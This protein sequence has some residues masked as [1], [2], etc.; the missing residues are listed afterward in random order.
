MHS[1][2][3]DSAFP[4]ATE[5]DTRRRLIEAAGEV[6]AEL[7]FRAATVR[8]ITERAGV[9]VAAINYH[10]RDKTE[11][12]AACLYHAKCTAIEAAGEWGCESDEPEE[13]LRHFIDR[14]LR[15]MLNPERPKWH[16]LLISREMLEPTGA[17]DQLVEQGIR[18]DCRELEAIIQ[19]L[20]GGDLP[21]ERVFMLAFSVVSQCL[22]Y[23][24]NRPIIE[25][26]YPKFRTKPPTVEHLTEHIYAF[27]VTAIREFAER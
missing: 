20:T 8:Q 1:A 2:T 13:Q 6:F 21:R 18:P 16:H 3:L 9:N 22:F 7:G 27:S 10:F 17:L 14:M 5:P 24:Q 26:L 4:P 19:Q 12:Y 15:R 23:L 11:L 25:R